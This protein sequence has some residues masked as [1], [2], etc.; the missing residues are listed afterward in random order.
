M[1]G[2]SHTFMYFMYETRYEV[3]SSSKNSKKNRLCSLKKPF[4][5]FT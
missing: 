5:L 3:Y 1:L 2:I 4:Y